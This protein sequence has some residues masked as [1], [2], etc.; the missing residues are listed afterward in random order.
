M[1][2]TQH[3]SDSIDTL[4]LVADLGSNP[5][6]GATADTS[7]ARNTFSDTF[8]ATT[9]ARGAVVSVKRVCVADVEV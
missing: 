1:P 6:D 9:S 7:D 5:I 8:N 2:V 3:N 4:D